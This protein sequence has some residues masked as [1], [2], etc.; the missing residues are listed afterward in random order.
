MC[1]YSSL[2]MPTDDT[3]RQKKQA[4]YPIKFWF[5]WLFIG[6]G[7]SGRFIMNALFVPQ[8]LGK[9]RGNSLAFPLVLAGKDR[10]VR[11]LT[12]NEYGGEY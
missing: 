10:G 1:L 2:L 8:S 4:L 3:P 11:T 12:L 9:H 6:V 7:R 5:A